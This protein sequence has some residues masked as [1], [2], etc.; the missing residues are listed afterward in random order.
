MLENVKGILS[1]CTFLGIGPL[2][3]CAKDLCCA[4]CQQSQPKRPHTHTHTHLYTHMCIYRYILPLSFTNFWPSH[5]DCLTRGPANKLQ[6]LL[7][8]Q[9]ASCLF[10]FLSP[11]PLSLSLPLLTML[12]FLFHFRIITFASQ[13]A[14]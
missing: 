10:L 14:L 5:I 6:F 11:P 1:V 12:S 4:A 8:S 2:D 9:S 13:L 7:Q 3:F